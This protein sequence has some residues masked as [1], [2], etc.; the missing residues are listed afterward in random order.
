MREHQGVFS[1]SA[2]FISLLFSKRKRLTYG[3]TERI[4][5]LWELVFAITSIL[6]FLNPA[7]ANT[8]KPHHSHFWN[9]TLRFD[10]RWNE[11]SKAPLLSFDLAGI[12]ISLLI[13]KSVPTQIREP[14]N[15]STV[16]AHI[17]DNRAGL[18]WNDQTILF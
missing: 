3:I 17:F 11:E 2:G 5:L 10:T 12:Q 18:D 6:F 14:D 15:T 4:F 16:F 8:S 1:R 9:Y 7:V 13:P